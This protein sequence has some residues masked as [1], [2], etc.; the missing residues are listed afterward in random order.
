MELK[1]LPH[2]RAFLLS[3]QIGDD[4][5]KN[6]AKI[7]VIANTNPALWDGKLPTRGI[8]PDT[9]FCKI[10]EATKGRPVV[11]WWW[12]SRQREPVPTVVK[13]IYQKLSFDFAVMYPKENAWIYV[14]VQPAAETLELLRRQEQ[15]KAFIL[16]SLVNKNFPPAQR[17]HKRLHLGTVLG[18]PDLKRIFAFISFPEGDKR[19]QA[20][21]GRIPALTRL[22][23]PASNTANWNIRLPG[24]KRVYGSFREIIGL[25]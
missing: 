15:L 13:D 14:C 19:Y 6:L 18:S 9:G 22:V 23:H 12:Y 7:K 24:D 21:A 20:A 10:A 17:E 1:F 2:L 3:H 4:P 25:P 11:P 16:I 8:H 5:Y